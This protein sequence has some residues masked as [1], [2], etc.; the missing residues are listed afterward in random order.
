M[1]QA[2]F[3]GAALSSSGIG[4]NHFGLC[5]IFG[6][7]AESVSSKSDI[8]AVSGI[9][10]SNLV[11][12]CCC[13]GGGRVVVVVFVIAV[14]IGACVVDDAGLRGE[15][16]I[17]GTGGLVQPGLHPLLPAQVEV[18]TRELYQVSPSLLVF[19]D[20]TSVSVSAGEGVCRANSECVACSSVTIA[21]PF[22]FTTRR[23][24]VASTTGSRMATPPTYA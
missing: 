16:S 20:A 7:C 12:L 6:R 17:T 3:E 9:A 22:S 19:S 4:F 24:C 23:G 21:L 13:G 2:G 18:K 11:A 14:K 10:N 8:L 1:T 15:K 5:L